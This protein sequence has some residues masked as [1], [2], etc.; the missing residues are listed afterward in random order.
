MSSISSYGHDDLCEVR[1]PTEV[2]SPTT[3]DSA[4]SPPVAAG[5][6]GGCLRTEDLNRLMDALDERSIKFQRMK[7]QECLPEAMMH[8]QGAVVPAVV[9]SPSNESE[10]VQTL[11]ILTKLDL[12]HG[13]QAVSVKSGGHGYFNGATCADIM[14]NLST[15]RSNSPGPS[16]WIARKYLRYK[17]VAFGEFWRKRGDM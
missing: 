1:S 12:Y 7:G 5:N 4:E 8:D 9:V 13:G 11:Q 2:G 14:L 17:A 3:L 10:V 16:G 6:E 15:M